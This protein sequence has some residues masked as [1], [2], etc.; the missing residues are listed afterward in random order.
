MSP[1]ATLFQRSPNLSFKFQTL[2]K[3]FPN[4]AAKF[5]AY[6]F[7]VGYVLFL[8]Y[9]VYRNF[10]TAF[11]LFRTESRVRKGATV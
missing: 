7:A 3:R 4:E 10:D 1:R 11:A 9:I 6:Y 8:L 2:N 5:R